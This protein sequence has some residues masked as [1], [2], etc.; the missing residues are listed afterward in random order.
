M[1]IL[2]DYTAVA[3][4]S[5]FAAEK[6]GMDQEGAVRH[7]IL[8]S[9]RTFNMKLKND[10]GRMILCCDQKSWRK[11]I[12]AP[13]KANRKKGRDEDPQKW[14]DIFAI[15][16]KITEE[17]KENLPYEV[18]E[19]KDCEADDVIAVLCRETENFG[20][21]EPMIIISSDKDFCQLQLIEG[22]R[23]WCPRK[24]K[25]VEERD[26]NSYIFEHIVRGDGG[27]GVPNIL[28][29]DDVF[30]QDGVRQTPIS[31]NKYEGWYSQWK[32]GKKIE[33]IFEDKKIRERAL[34]NK[35]LVSLYDIPSEFYDR[36]VET[37]SKWVPKRRNILGYLIK[38]R[39]RNLT[40]CVQDFVPSK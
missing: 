9:L 13:Y 8:N 28:S 30:L 5:V 1:A 18:L 24:K 3:F 34:M 38:K 10:Y 4:A 20:S 19:V 14:E 6:T 17:I 27:D 25:F 37:H 2:V 26:P 23:Q 36:V 22:V 16:S 12:F 11:S 21:Y 29:S 40:S 15:L 35:R 33:E 32:S 31:K 7:L 39:C